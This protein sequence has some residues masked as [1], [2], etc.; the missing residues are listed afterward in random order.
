MALQQHDGP[1][2]GEAQHQSRAA[3][4]EATAVAAQLD[5]P[6]VPVAGNGRG[7]VKPEGRVGAAHR[8]SGRQSGRGVHDEQVARDE[9]LGQLGE[10]GV[11]DAAA[12]ASRDEQPH[13]VACGAAHLGGLAGF[14]GLGKRRMRGRDAHG[15]AP[16]AAAGRPA[17][18]SSS[19]AT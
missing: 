11:V 19:R 10:A 18:A 8:D 2:G 16:E 14:R 7:Q 9:Q 12:R 1:A 5:E 13:V 3:G 17:S 4:A 6:D 15:A